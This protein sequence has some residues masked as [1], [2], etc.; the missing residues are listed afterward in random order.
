MIQI[1]KISIIT[2][3]YNRVGML[4]QT[5]QS[6]LNEHY[7]NLEYIIID[8]GSTD[9]T[10][11]LIKYYAERAEKG[12][13]GNVEFKWLSEKDDGMYYAIMKGMKMASGEVVAWLNSDDMYHKN[14]LQ[15]VGHIFAQLPQVEWLTGTPTL[16]NAEGLCAKTFHTKYWSWERFKRGDFRWL[17]QESTFFRRELFNRVGGLNLEYKLAADFELWCK[18]FQETKLYSVNT[19]LGGFRQ[20]GNQLSVE[21]VGRYEAEV[22][23]ICEK[24][25]I[26]Y[27]PLIKNRYLRKLCDKFDNKYAVCYS[28]A[29]SKWETEK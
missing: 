26:R 25:G 18:M 5:M 8:G 28:F 10:V 22:K 21:G 12:E 4:E 2:P 9:G 17:Q 19:I 6:V 11:D 7:S 15:I 3:V 27:K 1:P 24:Y 13:F 16:Y 23:T 20:H 29:D 14:A